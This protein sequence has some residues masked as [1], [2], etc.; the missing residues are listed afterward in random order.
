MLGGDVDRQGVGGQPG[1]AEGA[2]GGAGADD[3]GDPQGAVLGD[4][5]DQGA[6][7]GVGP[8]RVGQALVERGLEQGL[9]ERLL[10]ADAAQV[11]PRVAAPDAA[12]LADVQARLGVP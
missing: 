12:G 1:G 3:L 11:G 2:E 4:L 6:D 7:E 5:V 9:E 10:A 8:H